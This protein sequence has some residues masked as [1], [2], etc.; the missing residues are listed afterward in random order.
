MDFQDEIL[1]RGVQALERAAEALERLAEDPVVQIET[2]PPVCPHCEQM[3]PLVR[4][5][6]SSAQGKLGEFVIQAHCLHC[7]SVIYG[8]PLQ[9]QCVK[10]TDEA[11]QILREMEEIRG[12]EFNGR[13]NT[14]AP[15]GKDAPRAS[16]L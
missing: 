8:V 11:G 10:T 6:E 9:W 2:G 13:S 12:S 5:D 14:G 4:V 1:G 7:N 3:N 16:G 15:P